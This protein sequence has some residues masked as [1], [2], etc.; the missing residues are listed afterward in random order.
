MGRALGE[1][2]DEVVIATK[3]GL[4]DSHRDVSP[5]IYSDPGLIIERCEDSLR[6]LQTDR[7][8]VY[9]CHLWWDENTDAFLAA[10]D[11][12]KRQGKIRAYGVSTDGIDHLRH[13]DKHGTCDVLQVDYSIFNRAA[14]RELLPY[15]QQR[16]IGTVI[17]G[18][19]YKGLLT[20]KF[21]EDS[22][23]PEGDIRHDWP[24]RAWYREA[25][26]KV[27]RLRALAEDGRELSHVALQFVLAHP[28]VHTPSQA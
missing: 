5:N 10:F 20:G 8:D 6:R 17:R 4:W 23:F 25:L 11:E 22:A 3:V 28:A 15:C 13:F 16:N 18:P 2:R 12:L 7:I 19:L 14:E 9:F 21:D 24:E 1:R 27:D 26:A